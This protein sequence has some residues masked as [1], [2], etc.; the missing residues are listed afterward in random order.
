CIR[1]R[2]DYCEM[3]CGTCRNRTCSVSNNILTTDDYQIMEVFLVLKFTWTNPV[4]REWNIYKLS[5]ETD[6]KLV[7]VSVSGIPSANDVRFRTSKFYLRSLGIKDI[8]GYNVESPSLKVEERDITY[9]NGPETLTLRYLSD[10][11]VNSA[12]ANNYIRQSEDNLKRIA[13]VSSIPTR[14]LTFEIGEAT[15]ERK[16]E[17]TSLTFAGLKVE[18]LNAKTF[19]NMLNLEMLILDHVVLKDLSFLESNVL[20]QTLKDIIIKIEDEVDMQVFGPFSK[21][22]TIEVDKYIPFKN[23]T[24]FICRTGDVLCVFH[25]GTNGIPCPSKCKCQYN[26]NNREFEINCSQR[27]L[28]LVPTL[29]VPIAG[30]TSLLL[31]GNYITKLP[32][33]TLAGYNNVKKLNVSQNELTSLSISQLPTD[34]DDLDISYNQISYLDPEV[35]DYVTN[36]THFK[37]FGNKWIFYCNELHL[38]EFSWR[39]RKSVRILKDSFSHVLEMMDKT[40]AGSAAFLKIFFNLNPKKLYYEADE[41]AILTSMGSGEIYVNLKIMEDLHRLMWI[42]SAEYDEIIMYHLNASC[43]YRCECC[44]DPES[45]QFIINCMKMYL[46]FYPILPKSLRYNTTLNLDGNEISKL[47]EPPF[48]VMPGHASIQ[49]LHI[50]NNRLTEFPHHLLPE[51][52]TYLDVRNNSLNTLDDDVV[53]FMRFRE[54]ITEIKLSGN[55]WK[56]DCSTKSFLSLLREREPEEYAKTLNR[57]GVISSGGCPDACICC[58][59]QS[60]KDLS[61]IIDCTSKG[62]LEIPPVTRLHVAHNRLTIIDKLPTDL[63]YLDIRKNGISVLNDSTREFFDKRMNSSHLELLLSGNPW[64]C[65][66][67][68]LDFLEFVKRQAKYI[69]DTSL[70]VCSD[71]GLPLIETEE[72]DICPSA[73]I[74]YAALAASML[75]VASSINVFICFRQPI[76]IWFYEHEICLSLAARRDLDQDKRYDA[77]LAF[78][79]KDEELIEEFVERLEQGKHKFRLCF[80]LRDWLV[81]SSIPDCISQSVKDSRRIIILMTD[82]F[83]KSTW[84]RLEF[85]LA[86]HATSK[87]RCKRLIVVLYPDVKNF[88]DLDSELRTYMVL[89]TYLERN[90]PNFWNKLI[91][92]M[93]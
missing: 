48:L 79:H 66:C 67:E 81:G 92:S 72:S 40:T 57:S 35:L 29:P 9:A 34:L 61:I 65:D 43:P 87:D 18:Y 60:S 53:G 90:N 5:N 4:F 80:Y 58:L 86:L 68:N 59:D 8:T 75:V 44:V 54:G 42:F 15:F 20:R 45:G 73:F 93:P 69:G 39:M 22:T 63:V 47:S 50:Q 78:C 36:L 19:H 21:L 16:I 6:I 41:D 91:Y 88:D 2:E 71:T 89:N 1:I 27:Y 17:L 77:F 3:Y 82:N 31:Q 52:L 84:G 7:R 49:E 70:V 33:K 24:A 25:M 13:I 37:Q 64:T 11:V 23:L 46:E 26:R 83:L 14:Q 38:L 76:L 12:V 56:S 55:P 74:Y 51:N 85:R 10:N 30:I 32:N 28:F 62:L